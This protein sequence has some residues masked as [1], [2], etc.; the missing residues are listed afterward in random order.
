M[1]LALVNNFLLAPNNI[2]ARCIKTHRTIFQVINHR[3]LP[4]TT[5]QVHALFNQIGFGTQI[6]DH[7]Y[8]PLP[9]FQR[10]LALPHSIS[11]L[12]N[13]FPHASAQSVSTRS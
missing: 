11:C 4:V 6:H 8:Q 5:N 10:Y 1:T 12:E 2:R 3:F 9:H 13:L 7:D